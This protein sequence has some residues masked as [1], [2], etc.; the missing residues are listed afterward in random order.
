M[1]MTTLTARTLT[2]ALTL[3]QSCRRQSHLEAPVT[4]ARALTAAETLSRRRG[5]G[6]LS[7]R[8]WTA[9]IR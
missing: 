2:L 4:L 5:T 7:A 3:T 8:G 9:S 1:P 6:G